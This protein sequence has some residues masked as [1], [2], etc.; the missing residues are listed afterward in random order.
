MVEQGKRIHAFEN[1]LNF[2]G[3]CQNLTIQEFPK[4][5]TS[6]SRVED[7]TAHSSKTFPALG[8]SS[9]L[10]CSPSRSYPIVAG[11]ISMRRYPI[12][13]SRNSR[14]ERLTRRAY[15]CNTTDSYDL[16]LVVS[17]VV[18]DMLG[19]VSLRDVLLSDDTS[20]TTYDVKPRLDFQVRSFIPTKGS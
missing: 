16:D 10:R 11:S 2:S 15:I 19:F 1:P 17:I 20:T 9:D 14:C 5:S 3:L 7:I 13:D 4:L 8:N 6:L 12:L 18:A